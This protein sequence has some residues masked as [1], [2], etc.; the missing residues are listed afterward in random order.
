MG[1]V[2]MIVT[3]L[4]KT[5]LRSDGSVSSYTSSVLRWCREQ[6]KLIVFATARP[7]RATVRFQKE[8]PV[9]YVIAN[10]GATIVERGKT[11]YNNAFLEEV[12]QKLISCFCSEPSI[13]AV[14][15]E[16]GMCL[17][18]SENQKGAQWNNREDWNPVFTD[19]SKPVAG[20]SPKIS[21][22][23]ENSSAFLQI[24]KR[25]PDLYEDSHSGELWHQVM[26]RGSSKWNAVRLLCNRLNVSTEQIIAFGDD[27]N[28]LEMLQN[29][30]VGVAVENAIP[31]VKAAARFV[32]KSSDEDG[33]AKFLEQSLPMQLK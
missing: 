18:V 6:G 25:Y 27:R 24:L 12:K 5:L 21:V 23:C 22:E 1:D 19:F 2:K 31:E 26:K 13:M 11:I 4:D 8:I 14:T 10:N 7:A 16:T 30:G 20:E 29:C 33:V 9:D 15:V 28:D 3:D 17:Y 32:T